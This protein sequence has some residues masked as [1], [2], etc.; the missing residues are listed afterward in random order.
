MLAGLV[1]WNEKEDWRPLLAR[2]QQ[3]VGPFPVSGWRSW[4]RPGQSWAVSCDNLSPRPPSSL[5]GKGE[6]GLPLRG[7]GDRAVFDGILYNREELTA[8]LTRPGK[9][10]LDPLDEHLVLAAYRRWGAS[11]LERLVGDFA[12]AIWDETTKTL[13][14]AVDPFGLRPLYYARSEN[15]FAFASRISQLRLLPWVGD[16]TNDQMVVSF[17]MDVWNDAHQTFYRSVAQLP[18]GH[19]LHAN[20]DGAEVRRYWQ[21]GAKKVCAAGKP[22][23]VLEQFADLFRLAVRQRLVGGQSFG[24]LMS[25][26]LDSTSLAGMVADIYRREP[27]TL[28]APAVISAQFGNLPCDESPYIAAVLRRLPFENRRISGLNGC[29]PSIDRFWEDLRRH[30]WPALNRQRP[31]F[32]AFVRA[33]Q[34]LGARMLLNG[35]GGDELTTDYRYYCDLLDRGGVLGILRSARLVN[36]VEGIPTGKALLA[37]LREVCPEEI[38]HVYRWLRRRAN[39]S[40]SQEELSLTWLT[41]QARRL[42]SEIGPPAV[43]PPQGFG[44]QTLELA[45]Q[46][47]SSPY[48]AWANRWLVDE[49]AAN[50]IHCRFPFLDRRLFEFVF[51][52]PPRLRPRCKGPPWFKPL[53]SQGLA[54]FLP[55]ELRR[56]HAKVHFEAYNCYV[57]SGELESLRRCL[58]DD[59]QWCSESFV[60]RRQALALFENFRIGPDEIRGDPV[61]MSKRIDSLRRIAGLELWFRTR[62]DA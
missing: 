5:E 25:G 44:S 45:W 8:S 3:E 62:S 42:A 59:D 18:P 1:D 35:L 55:P 10:D 11:F 40:N 58:F 19:C 32:D 21:P 14:A 26:G 54:A 52:I 56:R 9:G 22:A 61:G 33:A 50:G 16:E 7:E 24:I 39:S 12:L 31:L 23:E 20:A 30:E 28:S 13:F 53:I 37:L 27:M 60:P 34:S 29:P 57:F 15:R 43:P 49:F 38:K 48:A 4:H 47:I 17:L 41:P 51:S 6:S 36:R 2:M 46:I